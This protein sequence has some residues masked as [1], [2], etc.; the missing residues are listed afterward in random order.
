MDEL[1]AVLST[2]GNGVVSE[3]ELQR[4]L[5]IGVYW[6]FEKNHTIFDFYRE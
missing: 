5:T 2:A 1:A 3:R 4:W 6:C